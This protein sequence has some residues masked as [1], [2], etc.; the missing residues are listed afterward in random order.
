[1]GKSF[2]RAHPDNICEAFKAYKDHCLTSPYASQHF[3]TQLAAQLSQPIDK[4]KGSLVSVET[5][6]ARVGCD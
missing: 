2:L 3:N 6:Y 5:D 1:M 4:H